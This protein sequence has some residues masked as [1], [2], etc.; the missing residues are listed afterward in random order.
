MPRQNAAARILDI[1]QQ[2]RTRGDGDPVVDAWAAILGVSEAEATTRAHEVGRLL[3]LLHCEAS[4][5][6]VG[7]QS[8]AL[9]PIAYASTLDRV[10]ASY[11]L[12][13]LGAR[14]NSVTQYYGEDVLAALRIFPA[15]LPDESAILPDEISKI[16]EMIRN[17]RSKV[18]GS[19]LPERLRDFLLAQVSLLERSI[20][21]YRIQGVTALRDASER[22]AVEWL[23]ESEM[24]SQYKDEPA[25]R[26]VASIWPK[27]QTVVK[28]AMFVGTFVGAVLGGLDKSLS[29]AE[30]LHLLPERTSPAPSVPLALPPVSAPT[31]GSI[32]Q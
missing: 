2:I 24:V 22:A 31:D 25:V 4:A 3:S 7:L 18:E 5:V 30:K 9:E 1:A 11:G 15:L 14:W 26:E 32:Q 13:I 10:S 29:V 8:T 28:N 27:V 17:L 21:D 23:R 12:T 6:R 16:V 20:R 19:S